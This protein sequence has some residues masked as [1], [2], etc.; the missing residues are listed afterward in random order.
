M[1]PSGTQVV[2]VDTTGMTRQVQVGSSSAELRLDPIPRE[3]LKTPLLVCLPALEKA[4]KKTDEITL[5][6]LAEKLRDGSAVLLVEWLG[7][8]LQGCVVTRINEYYNFKA[9]CVLAIAAFPSKSRPYPNADSLELLKVWSQKQGCS[10]I[11][12]WVDPAVQRLWAR[13]GFKEAKRLV[14]M[15]I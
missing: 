11:E 15:D 5:E 8:E 13:I 9:C 3:A 7:E 2:V 4:V 12:G 6:G 1:E 10:K 14:R